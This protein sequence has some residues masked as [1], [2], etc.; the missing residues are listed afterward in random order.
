LDFVE[1]T[2]P[3]AIPFAPVRT[4]DAARRQ[5]QGDL[6]DQMQVLHT[7]AEAVLVQMHADSTL[8][9]P[10]NPLGSLE[11]FMSAAEAYVKTAFKSSVSDPDT[12]AWMFPDA[13]IDAYFWIALGPYLRLKYLG[14][15]VPGT[16]NAV[17]RNDVSLYDSRY[18]QLLILN[19]IRA[20]VQKVAAAS[21]ANAATLTTLGSFIQTAIAAKSE[22]DVGGEAL[23]KMYGQVA[24]VSSRARTG[25]TDLKQ[26][27]STFEIRRMRIKALQQGAL[28]ADKQTKRAY[29]SLLLWLAAFV[30]TLGMAI[31]L[32]LTDNLD[33]FLLLCGLALGI[34]TLFLLI[35]IA[36]RAIR[37][38]HVSVE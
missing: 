12:L 34:S 19:S 13:V 5:S 37:R 20:S 25:V 27:S 30:V 17:Q 18:A 24:D 7:K 16:W 15:F 23:K 3:L 38:V 2:L 28:Q 8:P 11:Y 9:K 14:T 29:T 21:P 36:Q 31:V 32:I 35:A 1:G 33:G 4:D 6:P 22:A 10:E 26:K